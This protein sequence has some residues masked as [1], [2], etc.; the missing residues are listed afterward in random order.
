MLYRFLLL[1]QREEAGQNVCLC[2]CGKMTRKCKRRGGVSLPSPPAGLPQRR[3]VCAHTFK[4][5]LGCMLC[6][7]FWHGCLVKKCGVQ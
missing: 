7:V 4:R 6:R 3:R 5:S 1:F 2:V